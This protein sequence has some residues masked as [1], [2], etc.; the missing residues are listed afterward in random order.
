MSFTGQPLR[1]SLDMRAL[2]R[3]LWYRK[4]SILVI[5]AIVVGSALYFTSRQTP[6]YSSNAQVLVTPIE[7]STSPQATAN[8][9][10]LN[11]E[12]QIAASTD[13]AKLAAQ[14][15]DGSGGARDSLKGLSVTVEPSTEILSFVYSSPDPSAAKHGANAFARAYLD[16]RRQQTLDN[17]KASSLAVQQQI[18]SLN[19]QLDQVEGEISATSDEARQATLQAEANSLSSQIALLQTQLLQLTAPESLQVGQVVAK[20]TLPAVPYSPSYPRNVALAL[21]LGL[22]L[23]FAQAFVRDRLDPRLHDRSLVEQALGTPV[24]A[25][26]PHISKWRKRSRPLLITTA[27][28]QSVYAEAYRTLRTSVLFAASQH[29]VGLILITSSQAQEGKTATTANL[30][31]ALGQ[32]GKRVIAVS[33]DLRR[34]RLADFLGPKKEEGLSSILSGT[35]TLQDALVRTD[36]HG[37]LL[38]NSG[39]IPSNPAELLGSERMEKL[40]A[41]LRDTADYVLI[42]SAPVLAAADAMTL[43]PLVDSVLFVADGSRTTV[44]T[45]GTAREQLSHVDARLLGAVLNNFNPVRSKGAGAYA[46]YPSPARP[47][48]T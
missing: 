2:G 29:D 30:G 20:G 26:V 36:H 22:A 28:P 35:A 12:S 27:Q 19:K 45:L 37:L 5:V 32:A 4:W 7:T 25:A 11:T 38:L 31:V 41:E 18:D 24:L 44:E 34:P 15:L 21:F 10:N 47:G 16:Y 39:P 40:L 42:D 3:V 9:L 46:A 1:T 48:R 13:V 17:L 6:L 33:G 8:L 23:G 43:V 14:R